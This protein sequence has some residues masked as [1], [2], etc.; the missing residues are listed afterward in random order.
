MY[1]DYKN[2]KTCPTSFFYLKLYKT[3]MF[4]VLSCIGPCTS[5]I[6]KRRRRSIW[7]SIG[8]ETAECARNERTCDSSRWGWSNGSRTYSS[9][10]AADYWETRH[11]NDTCHIGPTNGEARCGYYSK[12]IHSICYI[13]K[14]I[15]FAL[16]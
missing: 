3:N 6:R 12:K 10:R 15:Q 5:A 8:N 13:R 9:I 1:S 11:I 4:T 14:Y 2:S 16:I 7:E